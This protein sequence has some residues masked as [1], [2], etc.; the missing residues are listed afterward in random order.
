[1]QVDPNSK[2][3]P[4]INNPSPDYGQ[5]TYQGAY[6][7]HLDLTNGFKL[8]GTITHLSEEDLAQAGGNWYYSDKS[9]NR[10]IYI[11]STLYTL[12]NSEIKANDMNT[13]KE[14]N[15]LIIP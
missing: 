4:A 6:I 14:T 12:S 15:K 7:Y 9:I 2:E 13:L 11:G 10:I 5:F 8:K 1:M 3:K